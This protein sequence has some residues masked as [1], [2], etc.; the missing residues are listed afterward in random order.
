MTTRT[1]AAERGT[2]HWSLDPSHT[3]VDFGVRHLMISTVRG[4]FGGVHGSVTVPGGDAMKARVDVTIDAASIDTGLGQRDDHLRSADFFDVTRFPKLSFKSKRVE[5]SG[6]SSL[7]L[8]GDLTIRDVTR[9]IGLEVHELGTV[10]DPWGGERAG[11]SARG[12]LNRRDFGLNW[13]QA[14]EAGGVLVGEDVAITLEAELVRN[15]A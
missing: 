1:P 11:F 12:R 6:D 8:V 10:R 13:N 3:S 15:A 9:E 2:T 4:R 7:R 14:L 5:R